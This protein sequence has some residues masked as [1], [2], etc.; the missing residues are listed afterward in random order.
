MPF[1]AARRLKRLPAD[2]STGA[3]RFRGSSAHVRGGSP[4]SYPVDS[5]EES[6]NTDST[7]FEEHFEIP[8]DIFR[9]MVDIRFLRR[10]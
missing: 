6:M 5:V 7:D 10:D 3:V 8:I 4:N 2:A 1:S 9:E